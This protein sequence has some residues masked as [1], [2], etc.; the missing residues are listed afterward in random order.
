MEVWFPADFPIALGPLTPLAHG[1]RGGP[2]ARGMAV[3]PRPPP[4]LGRGAL[5][6]SPFAQTGEPP[7]RQRVGA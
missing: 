5:G 3:G 6:A 2:R 7:G 4:A 1:P